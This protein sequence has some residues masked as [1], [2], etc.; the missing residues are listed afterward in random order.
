MISSAYALEQ[1]YA[2]AL[3]EYLT[4][5]QEAALMCAYELGRRATEVGLGVLD[6]AAAHHDALTHVLEQSTTPQEI[7]QTIKAAS[8][9]FAESLGPFEMTQRGFLEANEAL[10]RANETLEQRAMEM[11]SMNKEMES[12]SYSVSHD[13]RAPLRSVDGF[14]QALLEDYLDKLDTKGV[15]Y[16]KRV[17][18]ASQFM[19]Q[20]IDDL[21]KLSRLTRTEM[22]R[23]NVS[24]SALASTIVEGLR[25]DQPERQV[26]LTIGDDLVARGDPVLLQVVLENLLSN[27]WKFTSKHPTAT[28]EFGAAW[29]E[30]K[31]V[32]F[33]RDDGAGFDM[34]YANKLFGPFQRLHGRKEFEGTGIGLAT[35]QRIIHRHGGRIWAEGAVEK[36]ATFYFTLG[37]KE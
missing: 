4:S 13:L 5:T 37:G 15:D 18:A 3:R 20:L 21:L 6:M 28:I 11:E 25:K 27:A 17:R 7:L 10:R 19:E 29:Q 14:S 30:G 1:N 35:A 12:F 24:L 31:R 23:Q 34:A 8:E 32:Y 26:K 33:V 22:R 9:F 16:L 2:S 36:G